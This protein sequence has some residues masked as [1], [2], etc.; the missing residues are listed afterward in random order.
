MC[1]NIIELICYEALITL[2]FAVFCTGRVLEVID[3]ESH[4]YG[5]LVT[6]NSDLMVTDVTDL[7]VTDVTDLKHS[8]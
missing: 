4:L 7:M 6:D 1:K 5:G 8:L 2:R 3:S